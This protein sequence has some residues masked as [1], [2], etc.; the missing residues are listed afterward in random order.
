MWLVGA[1]IFLKE[2]QLLFIGERM[3]QKN[4]IV[5]APD[6][7]P[8]MRADDFPSLLRRQKVGTEPVYLEWPATLGGGASHQHLCQLGIR[9]PKVQ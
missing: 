4:G 8:A 2:M 3:S 1:F 9:N 6:D 5:L 7:R